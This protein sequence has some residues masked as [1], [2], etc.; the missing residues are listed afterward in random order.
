MLDVILCKASLLC[1]VL[2]ALEYLLSHLKGDL[3][4]KD[5]ESSCGV[6]VIISPEDIERVVEKFITNHKN[7]LLEKR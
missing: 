3:N 5:F 2:A 7:E 6:G 4:E 1:C